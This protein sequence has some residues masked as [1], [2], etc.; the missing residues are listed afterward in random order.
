MTALT[1]AITL[2]DQQL[3]RD[4]NIKLERWRKHA[5]R[6]G[7]TTPQ[8]II[9]K[10]QPIV[11]KARRK[12]TEN[13][14]VPFGT[15]THEQQQQLLQERLKIFYDQTDE[16]S[17][18]MY[19]GDI[20][21]GQYQE[22]IKQAIREFHTSAG[23]IGQG[24]WDKMTSQA[25]GRLGTPLREQ[26]KWFK[27]FIGY[28][29]ANRDTISLRYIQNRAR[30]YGEGAVKMA[31]IASTPFYLYDLLPWIPK[32]SQ[33]I[34]GKVTPECR[35]K[36]HCSWVSKLV[37]EAGKNWNVYDFTWTLGFAEH[38]DTCVSRAGHTV[39]L[40]VPNDVTVPEIIGGF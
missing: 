8:V 32:Q 7:A 10:E 18:K 37:S 9:V 35:N 12:R 28:I 11:L 22:A 1:Q 33:T 27:D 20:T 31:V 21:L 14:N 36:C 34:D 26:Y 29:D 5:K 2:F 3:A 15:F 25:W 4:V 24:G 17:L 38:C 6:H 19:S 40:R 13:I 30:M 39:T 23:V 16:L